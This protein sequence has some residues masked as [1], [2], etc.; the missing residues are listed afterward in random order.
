MTSLKKNTIKKYCHPVT[1]A[2]TDG[3]LI[4][5]KM[6]KKNHFKWL[7]YNSDGSKA[8]MCGN[9]AR[10]AA[11]YCY[12]HK[13][14]SSNDVTFLT[15]A[16]LVS[17]KFFSAKKI[18]VKMPPVIIKKQEMRLTLAHKNHAF[19]FL[20]TGVP[21][22]VKKIPS[23]ENIENHKN[24]A[25]YARNYPQLG[26]MGSNVTFY[27][28]NSTSNISAV[29]FERGVE[30]FTLACGTGAV[31]AAAT[32]YMNTHTKIVKVNMPGGLMIIDF[33]NGTDYPRMVGSAE[34]IGDFIPY[35]KRTPTNEKF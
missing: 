25:Q 10:C 12:E 18:Q 26:R 19:L 28:V 30:N 4:L 11:L 35:T 17:A 14:I 2:S 3:L 20:N 21:H 15:G 22:L 27:S 9:A 1:G 7:F 23:I 5:K 24:L 6:P 31:A 16:G 13:L 8:E 33:K 34:F 32:H 29:T